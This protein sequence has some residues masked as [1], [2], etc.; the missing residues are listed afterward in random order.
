MKIDEVTDMRP[1]KPER[2]EMANL[3]KPISRWIWSL[4]LR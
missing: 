3:S 4:S 1:Q 2:M